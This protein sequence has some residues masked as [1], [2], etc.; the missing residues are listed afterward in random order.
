M[1]NIIDRL[2]ENIS[3][4]YYVDNTCIDCD[5]CRS[6]APDFFVRDDDIGFSVVIRQPVTLAEIDLC[7]EAR[8][9]CPTESIGSDCAAE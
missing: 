8:T 4:P 2:P 6:V 3:G 1:A 7:E 5:Q 9:G